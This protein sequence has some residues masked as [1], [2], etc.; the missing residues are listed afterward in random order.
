MALSGAPGR[1]PGIQ[2]L[3][4]FRSQAI[5]RERLAGLGADLRMPLIGSAPEGYLRLNVPFVVDVSGL[6]APNVAVDGAAGLRYRQGRFLGQLSYDLRRFD[7][8]AAGGR[9]RLEE[10]S[11]LPFGAGVML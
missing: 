3:A 11:A 9:T 4:A 10:I 5:A 2:Y 8:P 6:A 7:F 1:T